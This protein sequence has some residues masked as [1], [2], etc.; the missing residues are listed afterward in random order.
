MTRGISRLIRAWNRFFAN[1]DL[2]EM[3]ASI[4]RNLTIL[5]QFRNRDV[6]S[7]FD[8]DIPCIKNLFHDFLVSLQCTRDNRKSSFITKCII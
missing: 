7:L 5:S 2:E 1:F 4:D 3:E 6:N 8:E